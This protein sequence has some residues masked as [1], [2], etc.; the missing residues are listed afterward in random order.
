MRSPLILNQLHVREIKPTAP[1]NFDATFHKPDHFPSADNA[2]QPGQRWQ[3]MLW[4]GQPLG[5]LFS[6]CGSPNTPLIQ[7]T[8]FAQKGIGFIVSG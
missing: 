8:V 1:F 3:T 2:W 5:L 7:L 4:Q 6:D